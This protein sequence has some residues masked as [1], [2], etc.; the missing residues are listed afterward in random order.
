MAA[1][2]VMFLMVFEGAEGAKGRG[3][4]RGSVERLK[5]RK[6]WTRL[7]MSSVAEPVESHGPGDGGSSRKKLTNAD[8]VEPFS[9]HHIRPS[10]HFHSRTVLLY[11]LRS[12]FQICTL[13]SCCLRL[14][15]SLGPMSSSPPFPLLTLPMTFQRTLCFTGCTNG[16]GLESLPWSINSLFSAWGTCWQRDFVSWIVYARGCGRRRLAMVWSYIQRQYEFFLSRYWLS[17]IHH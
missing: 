5:R 7:V 12:D 14:R 17:L 16:G 6:S 13:P 10:A 4:G 1:K 11:I 8:Q 2:I 15:R 3:R 9:E